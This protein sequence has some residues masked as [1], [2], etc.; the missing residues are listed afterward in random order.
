VSGYDH[1]RDDGR[2]AVEMETTRMSERPVFGTPAKPNRR[3]R[4][5]T[6]AVPDA[7]VLIGAVGVA[8]AAAYNFAVPVAAYDL[9]L[10]S[11]LVS[12]PLA[13]GLFL[14]RRVY[15]V[16]P[17]YVGLY[18]ILNLCMVAGAVAAI[19]PAVRALV[20]AP[21]T[22]LAWL[23]PV[24][25]FFFAGAGWSALR[26]AY[27]LRDWHKL[28]RARVASQF[29]KQR[30]LIVGAG[31]AG[32]A[33]MRVI[34]RAGLP[35]HHVV[36]F[37][38][39]DPAKLGTTI[40]GVRVLGST[41][42]LPG[43]V[44]ELAIDE[45][46]LAIPSATGEQMRRI[47]NLCGQTQARV[48][49]LPT[50]QP[51]LTGQRQLMNQLRDV[52]IEDLL[53]REPVTVEVTSLADFL[54]GETVLI[55]GGGGSIG[56]ELARQTSRLSPAG[57]V[58]IGKGEN[59][60]YEIEQELVRSGALPPKAIIADVRD[61]L[62]LEL[63]FEQTRPTVVFHAAAHKHVP[64]MQSNPI[65]AIRNNV[66]GTWLIAE[67]SIRYGV[68]RFIYVSTDKAVKPSSIMGATKRV[69]EMIVGALAQRADGDF[70]IVRF[71]NVLGSRGSLIP[72]L[73]AQ[74][75]AGGPVRITHPEMTRYFMTIPEAVQLILQAGSMGRRGEIF[76]L[77]MG[78][79]IRILDIAHDL[80]RLH[81][82]VPSDDIEI[83]FTG[84]RPGEKIHEELLYEQEELDPTE[85]PKINKVGNHASVDWDWLRGELDTLLALCES[86]AS[87]QAR[88]FLMELAWGKTTLKGR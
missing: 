39:D 33:I 15:S 52:H 62:S 36:G 81:G 24:L 26:V 56:S 86:G 14:W 63:A 46:L 53:K 2:A 12:L 85:H 31:D 40:H 60:V 35:I 54:S 77:D 45:L 73:T 87:D 68:K 65:E 7:L 75:K 42:V 38:D 29:K 57:L 83:Q 37:V 3:R 13:F 27:R 49:T 67:T 69:G 19:Q 55:S 22:D 32:E 48:R 41:N 6:E 1:K 66:L 76:I 72:A 50:V 17:R 79:P 11:M 10:L 71:G 30:T 28:P 9:I 82:L 43:L 8:G 25:S 23:S 34:S 5:L 21:A 44:E 70:G 51:I 47:V 4:I 80:I 59:S 20:A 61:R 58:L 18:D 16:T 74:I 84:V 78:E 88:Q 64:L